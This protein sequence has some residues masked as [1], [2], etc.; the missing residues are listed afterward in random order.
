MLIILNYD[1]Y[2]LRHFDVIDNLKIFT[3]FSEK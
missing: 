2:D 3:V 1:A